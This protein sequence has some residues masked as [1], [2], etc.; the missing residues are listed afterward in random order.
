MPQ[1]AQEVEL[2]RG[3][4]VRLG[5][6][7]PFR[8][9]LVQRNFRQ[10]SLRLYLGHGWCNFWFLYFRFAVHRITFFVRGWAIARMGKTFR[11]A[12]D[13]LPSVGK[14]KQRAG[15]RPNGDDQQGYT[16]CQWAT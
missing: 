3:S 2:F 11:A 9:V 10:I 5:G 1:A 16:K 12:D 7:F 15:D 4:P 8:H 6:S 13:E 14:M